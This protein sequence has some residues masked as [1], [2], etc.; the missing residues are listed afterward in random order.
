MMTKKK[1]M[2]LLVSAGAMFV[3][4]VDNTYKLSD[5]DTTVGISVNNLAIPLN[6]DSLV[7]NSV[8]D[9]DDDGKVKKDTLDNGSIIYAIIEEGEFESKEIEIPGFETES[10]DIDP[11]K[12]VLTRD[13]SAKIRRRKGGEATEATPSISYPIT[14]IEVSHFSVSGNVDPSI[15]GLE[16]IG[17][18][19]T[20]GTSI[21]VSDNPDLLKK[22]QSI[23]FEDITVSMPKG[24]EGE[25]VL[26]IGEERVDVTKC[27]DENT[28]C[29]DFVKYEQ[30]YGEPL[31]MKVDDG[32]VNFDVHVVAIDIIKAVDEVK[33][34]NGEFVLAS[35]VRVVGNVV[36]YGDEM[37][38]GFTLEELPEDIN[39]VCDS[40]LSEIVVSEF[41]GKIHYDIED[42]NI[43]PISLDD[44][45][46]M[47]SQD[48]SDIKL[49]NPQIYIRLTNP[50]ASNNIYAEAGLAMTAKRNDGSAKS[51]SL[52]EDR[53]T[54]NEAK[55]VYCLTT[56]GNMTQEQMH[57]KY[58]DA[59]N[60]KFNDFSDI[61]SG[62]GSNGLPGKIE[63]EVVKPQIP[64]QTITN[65]ELD[66]KIEKV[67]GTYL[68][69][70][71]L[72]LK[73]ASSFVIYQD[74]LD[75]WYDDTLE[76]LSIDAITVKADVNS[77]LP[78]K[79]E[80]SFC[81]IDVNGKAIK[82]VNSTPVVLNA[83]KAEQPIEL[84]INGNIEQLDG[85]IVR[86]KLIGA[87]GKPLAPT[88][89]I[90]FKNLKIAVNGQYV[91]EF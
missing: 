89:A 72:A 15:V 21:T 35:S 37:D 78:L 58:K 57:V 25:F 4:C 27:Y 12:A 36:I 2:M 68:F 73:D 30:L 84:N 51:I 55:N 31:V 88:Q 71:P 52:G 59:L 34:E 70:A 8:F 91:D 69:Y 74:T 86:A 3:S 79:V 46:D 23:N 49:A 66:K 11:I 77:E 76:K 47:L 85:I 43:D 16:K 28:G 24:L 54:L 33:F 40:K 80:L 7:L 39:Y 17:V 63:V 48:S 45:P 50:L 75:G 83:T 41:S 53:L 65:F 13:T 10:P 20:F 9:L 62:N 1:I 22:T 26:S 64:E 87:D 14:G 67:H 60:K 81:P 6:V 61:L 18:D 29:L 19:A 32:T 56:D 90:N 42:I 44:I 38:E 5:L 82:G